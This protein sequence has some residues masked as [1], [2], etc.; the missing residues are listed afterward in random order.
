MK[1]KWPQ[2]GGYKKVTMMAGLG[3]CE[4]E[5]VPVIA[6]KGEIASLQQARTKRVGDLFRT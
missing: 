1:T 3:E 2:C 5:N 6:A 4:N